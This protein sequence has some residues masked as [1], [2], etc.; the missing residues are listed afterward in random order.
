MA[1]RYIELLVERTCV[2]MKKL[3]LFLFVL[4]W[5]T[6][7]GKTGAKAPSLEQ[8]A[9]QECRDTGISRLN[10]DSPS[11]MTRMDEGTV[12]E[13]SDKGENLYVIRGN[14]RVKVRNKQ[15]TMIGSFDA[16]CML[17]KTSDRSFSVEMI[18]Y[19]NLVFD[20]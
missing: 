12:K 8:I 9:W 3:G 11:S 20:K 1:S 4:C 16:I 18:R 15:T 2:V 13:F 14:L 19:N 5:A 10:K 7:C 6:A 17:K